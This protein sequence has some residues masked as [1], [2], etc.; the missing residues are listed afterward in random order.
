MYIAGEFP[1]GSLLLIGTPAKFT[2]PCRANDLAM[3]LTSAE[4]KPNGL[5]SDNMCW[6]KVRTIADAHQMYSRVEVVL[7]E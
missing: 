2:T 7:C 6:A 1:K 4:T 5:C 3:V